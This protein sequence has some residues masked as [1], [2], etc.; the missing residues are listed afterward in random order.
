[1]IAIKSLEDKQNDTNEISVFRALTV[2][3]QREQNTHWYTGAYYIDLKSVA[4]H[5]KWKETNTRK[6]KK[7]T[8]KKSSSSL[9]SVKRTPIQMARFERTKDENKNTHSPNKFMK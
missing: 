8:W 4:E 1:M 6:R 2:L 7:N 9:W 5:E 3:T